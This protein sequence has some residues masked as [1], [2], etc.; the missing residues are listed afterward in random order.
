M[1]IPPV[2]VRH[3]VELHKPHASLDKPPSQQAFSTEAARSLVP[4]LEAIV[5]LSLP[6]LFL[7][8][9]DFQHATY[10]IELARRLYFAL[11]SA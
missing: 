3:V 8:V 9:A 4:V 2:L 1:G 7:E 5:A 6:R 11:G 10:P